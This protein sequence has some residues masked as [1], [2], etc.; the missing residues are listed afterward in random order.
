M[1]NVPKKWSKKIGKGWTPD[2]VI[3][4]GSL[5]LDHSPALSNYRGIPA[6]TMV[7][8]SS[9][10]EGSFKTSLALQGAKNIQKDLGKKIVYIDAEC[11]LTGTE[12]I[13][14]M[15][16]LTDE[17]HWI[18][19]QPESGEEA[20]EMA[21][22]FV[23]EDDIGGVIIDS[24]DAAVPQKQLDSEH[25]DADIGL[26][27]KLVTR[28]VRKFKSSVRTHQTVMWMINQKKVNL[29][30]MG[31]MGT[32]STGGRAINFYCKLNLDMRKTKSETSLKGEE[33]I[34]LM[35]SVKRSKL[36]PGS[37]IDIP[38]YAVQG[39]GIDNDAELKEFAQEQGLIRQSGSW[40]KTDDGETIGQGLVAIKN[41]CQ[42]NRDTILTKIRERYDT[43]TMEE[44]VDG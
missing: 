9:D 14:G 28:A 22:F 23:E 19:A 27:A 25:G 13:E 10:G 21:D 4:S 31:A 40:W 36:G 12:W 2:F 33:I 8:I 15:G 11:G 6:G 20:F 41:W 35:M 5:A 42:E 16:I 32:K 30:H 44:V 1:K 39:V 3:S 17:D 38:T 29:T 37:Y 43:E 24:I 26:H 34:P 7:Q 18:Y